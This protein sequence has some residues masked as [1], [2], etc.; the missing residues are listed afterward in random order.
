MNTPQN[1]ARCGDQASVNPQVGLIAARIS[2][3][4][5]DISTWMTAHHLKLKL[6][7]T[8][9]LF[10]SGKECPYI[11][12]LVT[13]KDIMLCCTANITMVVR[14]CRFALYNIRRIRPFRGKQHSA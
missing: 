3:C 8:E 11:D 2:E 14:F 12:L 10:V 9:L 1:W 4:L 13:V 5:A 6:D 7:K